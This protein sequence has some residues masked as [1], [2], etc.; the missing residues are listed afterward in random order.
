MTEHYACACQKT[1]DNKLAGRK[2]SDKTVFLASTILETYCA[3]L[4]NVLIERSVQ[5][6]KKTRGNIPILPEERFY[7]Y[8]FGAASSMCV[9]LIF[10]RHIF[11]DG[12][13][14]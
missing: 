1:W 7:G 8:H 5:E 12:V 11:A 14:I 9:Y 10:P 6:Q 13:Y 3:F 2:K 4:K